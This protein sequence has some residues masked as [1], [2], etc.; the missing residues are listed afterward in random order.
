[1]EVLILD[2]HDRRALACVRSLGRKKEYVIHVGSSRPVNATRFSRYCNRHFAY[3]DP[4]KDESQFLEVLTSYLSVNKIDVLI[5][6]G[7]KMAFFINKSLNHLRK[8]TNILQPESEVFDMARDKAKTL[9]A[10]QSI[11]IPIPTWYEY[12][13]VMQAN[14]EIFPVLIKPRISSASIG[15][16][17]VKCKAEFER[18]YAKIHTIYPDPIIQE[19]VPSGGGHF[20]LNAVLNRDGA[21]VCATTKNKIREFPIYGGPSTFFRTV[22]YPQIHE[23]G[24]QLLQ[25]IGWIGPAEV[26]FMID[27]RT[28]VPKLME[29]NPRMSA[30]IALSCYVGVNFPELISK[31]AMKQWD[32]IAVVNNKFNYFCQWFI[33]GD[34]LNFVYNPKRFKQE[35][36]YFG[37]FRS[38]LVHM[39]FDA[40]DIKPFF[41]NLY[42][43]LYSV[44]KPEK[45]LRYIKRSK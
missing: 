41:I 42:I 26:E 6:M 1:M 11:G 38:N 40:K 4:E 35:F 31:A 37:F 23:Y 13:E 44:L 36:G 45:V 25:S 33:P 5:P 32:E 43:L 19:L 9:E 34:L 2:G 28:G 24:L 20:Q 14:D 15:M 16:S 10:A 39:T 22:D 3:V 8:F 12:D 21:L 29:I 7:D 30:T 18:V 27:P 17:I